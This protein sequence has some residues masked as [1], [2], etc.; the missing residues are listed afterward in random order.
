MITLKTNINDISPDFTKILK[1]TF[2]ISMANIF[3][4]DDICT[5]SM[6]VNFESF[7]GQ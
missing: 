7:F 5:P 6:K 2:S 1:K 4:N 3:V